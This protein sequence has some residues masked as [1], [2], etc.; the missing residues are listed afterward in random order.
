[1]IKIENNVEIKKSKIKGAGKGVFSI[2]YIPKGTYIT[3]YKGY[4]INK[5]TRNKLQ[6]EKNKELKSDLKFKII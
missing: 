4:I 3:E 2:K 6:K 1:M 5:K